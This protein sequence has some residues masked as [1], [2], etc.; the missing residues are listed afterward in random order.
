MKVLLSTFNAKYIHSS[1]ALR[2]L[3]AYVRPV[4]SDV[5]VREYTINNKL[6]E[7]LADIYDCR[8]SILGLACYIW[9][10]DMTLQLVRLLKQVLPEVIVVAGG[11]EVSFGSDELLAEN[12]G[13]DYCLSGE[14]EEALAELLTALQTGGDVQGID[15]LTW[16]LHGQTVTNGGFRVMPDLG[17]LPFPYSKDDLADLSERIVYYESSRGCP[18]SCQYCLSSATRGVRH[19]PLNR[20]L[21]DMQTFINAGVRQVK[22]VDRTFNADKRH[23]LPLLRHLAAQECGTNFHLE[24]A[25][26]RLDAEALEV[27]NSAPAGRFQLEI[28]IQSTHEPTLEAIQRRNNWPRIV[29]HVTELR[30]AGRI[31]L[32][33]D[34]I[35]GLPYESYEQFGQSFNDVYRL[36]PHMLQIGFLKLLKGSGI[37]ESAARHGYLFTPFAPYEVLANSYLSYG[38]IRQIQIMEDVFQQT[39]NS[40]RFANTLDWLVEQVG[41][42]PFRLYMELAAYWQRHDLQMTAHSAKSVSRFLRDFAAEIGGDTAL[43][44]ELLKFDALTS[45]GGRLRPDHLPWNGDAWQE[46]KNAFWRNEQVASKYIA[47]YR[48]SA[49]RE[50]KRLYHLEVFSGALL[51]QLG[52]GRCER[53]AVLFDYGGGQII[54]RALKESD[55]W[56]EET[57]AL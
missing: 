18:F 44:G 7:V 57:D 14:G 5:A 39:Y 3:A 17:A 23:Y 35:V 13:I 52:A 11:P 6:L 43:C 12:P 10:I 54:W 19:V 51:E 1:L 32:H 49:W 41:G 55:F 29:S 21:E 53:S 38:D 34:L 15:G 4:C 42:D 46:Q 24:I 8:P 30:R 20:V 50:I 25:A 48:F 40:G 9:N 28:G 47:G 45:D 26:D 16:R 2:S 56:R 22:F 31:H 37:R 33:L 36:R 27:L